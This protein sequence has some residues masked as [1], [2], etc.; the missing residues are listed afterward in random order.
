MSTRIDRAASTSHPAPLATSTPGW[1]KAPERGTS[2]ALKAIEWIACH[3]GRPTARGLLV[4]A[5]LY[6][7][8]KASP[9]RRASRA[10][11]HKVHQHGSRQTPERTPSLIEVYRHF[12]TFSG[13]L[14]DRIFLLHGE[15]AEFTFEVFN[16]QLIHDQVA[17]GKGALLLS[18]HLGSFEV[19]RSLGAIQQ[20]CPL[21]ILMNIAHNARMASWMATLNP[22]L[23]TH[24]IAP[25]QSDT[26]L[27]VREALDQGFL[28]GLLGDRVYGSEK[29]VRCTFLG[30]PAT[31]PAGP[32]LLAS[33]MQCPVI[34]AFGLYQGGNRYTL[35]FEQL[36]TRVVINRQSRMQDL[37]YWTQRYANRLAH[38]AQLA[39]YN[40]FNFYPFWDDEAP[41]SDP[42]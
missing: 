29:T 37:Q 9:Q 25:G 38:Y 1:L 42:C 15:F 34:L 13:T 36:A 41:C 11:L 26:L 17:S 30:R 16:A 39:P 8:A 19:L 24:I 20:R 4:P 10:F 21:K 40:W 12:H 5:T 18:A 2:L 33:L 31:F 27:K 32:M 22:D 28:V 23:A 7:L 35:H 6:F 3:L 14:L